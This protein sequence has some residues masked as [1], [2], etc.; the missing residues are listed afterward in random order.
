MRSA[1]V[2]PHAYPVNGRGHLEIGG[3]DAL[4]LAAQFGTPLHVLDEDRLRG[5]C[6]RYRQALEHAYGAGRVVYASKACCILA[7][8]QIAAQ[9]G[10]GVD[11][12]SGGELYTALRA[13]VDP[14]DVVF[15]GSN[16][17]PQ[18]VA[19]G[20]RAGVG[21]FVVDNDHELDL[22]EEWAE[23]LGRPADV[24]LRVTPGIEPHTHRAIRTGG[25]DSKFGFPLAPGH[26]HQAVFR[27]VRSPRLRFRGLHTHIGSQIADLEPFR[28]AAEAVVAFAAQVQD[29]CDAVVDEVNLG[30]GLAIRYLSTDTVPSIEAY[31]AAVAEAVASSAARHRL[32]PPRLYLEPGRS[33]VGDAGVTLYTVGAVKVIPGV[34][35]YVSVDGGMY[36]NPRPA[37]Y[38]ARYEAVVAD[39]PLAAP[40]QVVAL[41]GRCCESGDVL[42]WEAALPSVRSGDVVAVFSTGA[43]T[44]AMASNYNRFPRPAVVLAGGGR[45]RV[46]VERETYDDLIRK[47]VPL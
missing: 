27:V 31:V 8:C 1:T 19:D 7:T 32:P 17:T 22:L 46:V 28:L 16:K 40:D 44:Y 33:L 45:A 30:G 5:N 43:Y 36:E 15:H 12:A 11:V 41:A 35:T 47:D 18:E 3:V 10:L 13:G 29:A 21:R 2:G 39:R 20:L 42:I 37:L 34:R 24:L 6:R 4:E 23:R 38:G 9:E 25:A 14:A 26:A